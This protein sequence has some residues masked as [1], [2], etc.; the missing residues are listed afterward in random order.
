MQIKGHVKH[1]TK[2]GPPTALTPEQ[3]DALVSYLFYMVEHGYPL[4]VKA[5]GWAIV[6]RSGNGEQLRQKQ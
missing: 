4:M 5:Y 1:G 2:P 6:K 3:E